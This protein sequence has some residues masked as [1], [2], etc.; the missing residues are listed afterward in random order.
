[1]ADDGTVLRQTYQGKHPMQ[2]TPGMIE[3]LFS[4]YSDVS[5]HLIAHKQVM[6]FEGQPLATVTVNSI[7]LNPEFTA[8]TDFGRA[9]VAET[10]SAGQIA[11]RRIAASHAARWRRKLFGLDRAL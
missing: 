6:T 5:G 3:V 10:L 1:M 8:A 2:Q 7:E 4:E 11:R 9:G